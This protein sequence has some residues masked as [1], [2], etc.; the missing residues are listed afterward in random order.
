MRVKLNRTGVRQL[1]QSP[2]IQGDLTRRARAIAT[3]AGP[4]FEVISGPG[5]TRARAMVVTDTFD[6]M[7]AEARDRALSRSIDAGRQ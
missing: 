6:A 1:L 2:E 5:A 4:G 7:L 3:A